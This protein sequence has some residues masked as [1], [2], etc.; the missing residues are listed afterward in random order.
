[1]DKTFTRKKSTKIKSQNQ[2]FQFTD[3][4]SSLEME[5]GKNVILNILNYSKAL[6]IKKSVM[7]D[8]VEMILN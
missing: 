5:P 3:D 2:N 7:I 8:H 6:S 1:M 4:L